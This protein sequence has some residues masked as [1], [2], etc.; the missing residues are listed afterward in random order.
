MSSRATPLD[1]PQ[2]ITL[3]AQ[4]ATALRRA[5]AERRWR[6]SLPS[7][8]HL[9]EMLQVSRPTIRTALQQ[10]A[11][12]GLIEIR[13]GRRVQ[14]LAPASRP[15]APRGRLIAFVTPDPVEQMTH[16]A[17]RGVSEMRAHL[18]AHGFGSE[19]LVCPMRSAAAQR[20][21]LEIFVRQNG[22]G[23]CVLISVSK[24][25]Q[26]WCA[27]ARIPT[28][29]LGSCHETVHLPSLDIAYRA[30]CRHAAGVLHGKGHRRIALL[31]PESGAAGDLASE[32]GFREGGR[33]LEHAAGAET[34]VVR[35]NGTAKGLSA[36]LESLL[37][38]PRPPTALLVAKPVHTLAV[39]VHL[40]RRGCRVPDDIAVIARDSDPLFE[41]TI[42]HYRFAEETFARR[43]VRLMSRLVSQ[44]RL[45]PKPHL[46]FP[47]YV[48]GGTVN[49]RSVPAGK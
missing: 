3:S 5:I 44:G 8:R 11:Q 22:V 37:D 7:E 36:R 45:P 30:V 39:I 21:R 10:L 23:A 27:A 14:L 41:D 20:R 34:M 9:C 1:L 42:A 47:R 29:V 38:S 13:Q 26:Q 18:T 32:E 40:L 6:E 19:L 24:D 15:A 25:L 43:L 49:A 31:V 48:A 17:F 12:E 33:P 4:A 35:H 16:S 46:L 28:L 2:R